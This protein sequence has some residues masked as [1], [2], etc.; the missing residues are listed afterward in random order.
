MGLF[1]LIFF[2]KKIDN[3]KNLNWFDYKIKKNF[4]ERSKESE[5]ILKKYQNK[6]PVIINECYDE[7]KDR[8]KRKILL[9]KEIT[10][11]EFLYVLRTKFN[12]NS[13]ES[14]LVFVN[15]KIPTSTTS[16]IYLYEKYKEKDNFLYISIVKENTF[17]YKYN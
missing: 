16:M 2:Q 6:I 17:G 4:E 3:D 10:V 13:E 11:S 9:P 14:L 1:D 12:I 8:I 7:V 15:G 5:I